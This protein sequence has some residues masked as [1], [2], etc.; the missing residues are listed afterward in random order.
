MRS[1]IVLLAGAAFALMQGI[2]LADPPVLRSL[3]TNR[4][5][6]WT[7][8]PTNGIAIVQKS[9]ILQP[10]SWVNF[11]YDAS[12]YSRTS[13]YP[14]PYYMDVLRPATRT[15]LLPASGEPSAFFRISAQTNIPDP[16]LLLHFTFDDD[17]VHNKMVLDVS[18]HGNHGLA[19]GRPGYPTNWPSATVGPDGNQAAEFHV[20]YDGWGAY[21]AS[22]DY[23]G[24]PSISAFQN[25]AQAAI[26]FWCRYYFETGSG[27]GNSTPMNAG[28][29]AAGAFSLG[30]YYT[31]TT[32]FRIYTNVLD[33][34]DVFDFPDPAPSGDTGGWHHY[35]ITFD[36]GVING[37][38]DG[39]NFASATV[40]TPV[41]TVEGYYLSMAGWT[42]GETP[43]MD[44]TLGD[45]HPNNAW[46]NGALDDVRIYNRALGASEI[47]SLYGSFDH[48]PPSV[49]ANL[50]VKVDS[51]T[52]VELRWNAAT[53][54]FRVDGYRILRNG[55]AVGTNA[56]PSLYV[57][58]GLSPSTV[59]TYAVQAFDP[60]GNLSAPSASVQVTTPAAGSQVE[61]I[62]DDAYGPPWVTVT[63]GPWTTAN[64]ATFGEYYGADFLS[65]SQGAPG[66][67]T[68]RP[69]LPEPGNYAVYCWHPSPL[70]Y[71]YEFS[72]SAPFDIVT[73]GTTNTVYVNE[74]QNYGM[75]DLLGT[76]TFSAGT[77]G[78]VQVRP[79][80]AP[81]TPADAVRF[82]K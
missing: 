57:D 78:F 82:V 18:G 25:L 23:I 49:P 71:S 42:F 34:L 37:Y 9:T 52:Q 53:D 28:M 16:S 74:L 66:S 31:R 73:G 12:L 22:G 59:Y 38:F 15:M 44:N 36:H 47:R 39:T 5:L 62:V 6:T 4:A 2:G 29:N 64:S 81:I 17:F 45:K 76:F 30:R 24:M 63:G 56:S 46:I 40:L 68:F 26:C 65:C 72:S 60:G 43:W 7:V 58:T 10:S 14:Y 13:F 67:V 55:T 21:G 50:Q 3:Q 27:G 61:V 11:S 77:D 75:W 54:N 35:A 32:S 33:E 70:P 48:Q 41:L 69:I 80:P 8:G 19:Y 51:S 79:A 1:S 20:Y